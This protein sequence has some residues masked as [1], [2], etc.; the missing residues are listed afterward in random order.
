MVRMT[1]PDVR[2]NIVHIIKMCKYCALEKTSKAV[3]RTDL[4]SCKIRATKFP[5]RAKSVLRSFRAVQNL[6]YEIPE[7]CKIRVVQIL[8]DLGEQ[9]KSQVNKSKR[10]QD[11][12][13][14]EAQM[15]KSQDDKISSNGH[16]QKKI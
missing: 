15:D 1:K 6:C 5:G 3:P 2:A 12:N 7:T 16:N 9:R 11:S 13:S 4:S 8:C 10:S 14:N